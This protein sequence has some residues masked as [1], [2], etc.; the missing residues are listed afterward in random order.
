MKVFRTL[1][2]FGIRWDRLRK[3]ALLLDIMAFTYCEGRVAFELV[4]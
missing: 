4:A 1:E 2:S 3:H